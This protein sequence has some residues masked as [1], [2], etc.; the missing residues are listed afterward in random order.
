MF[1]LQCRLAG[2]IDWHSSGCISLWPKQTGDTSSRFPLA[3]GAAALT[4]TVS[5]A[6]RSQPPRPS[7]RAGKSALW[8]G[9]AHL[10][11]ISRS[12]RHRYNK[13]SAAWEAALEANWHGNDPHASLVVQ[14]DVPK[15]GT[16]SMRK[17]PAWCNLESPVLR[18]ITGLGPGK[19]VPC[20]SQTVPTMGVKHNF[21]T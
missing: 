1:F 13:S 10:H 20:P 7:P 17:Y 18:D 5:S 3:P 11:C 19:R 9:V 4:I 2:N 21:A 8:T 16:A 15:W 12:D 14:T 6:D